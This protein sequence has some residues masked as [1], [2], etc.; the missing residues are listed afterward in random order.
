MLLVG[1]RPPTS[2]DILRIWDQCKRE[3]FSLSQLSIPQHIHVEKNCVVELH[4]FRDPTEK[5]YSTVVF[6]RVVSDCR[7]PYEIVANT[8]WFEGHPHFLSFLILLG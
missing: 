2:E 8:L 6:L 4:R 1:M 3:L 5:C 7:I